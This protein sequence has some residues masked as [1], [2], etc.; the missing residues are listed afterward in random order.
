MGAAFASAALAWAAAAWPPPP[1]TPEGTA[2]VGGLWQH[3]RPLSRAAAF[4][5]PHADARRLR[6]RGRGALAASAAQAE[7]A[8]GGAEGAR[9]SVSSQ[10]GGS[11]P[12]ASLR[13]RL[14][15]APSLGELRKY[16][17]GFALS[18]AFLGCL[19]SCVM[20]AVSWPV[21]VMRTGG[22]PLLFHPALKVNPKFL[23][24]V[25]AVYFSY[26]S[27]TTPFLLA[28]S[29]GLAPAFDWLLKTL[30]QRIGCPQW[31]AMGILA[32]LYIAG[33]FGLL[34]LAVVAACAI[35]RVP[36]WA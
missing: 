2:A 16:G 36:V 1:A 5:A 35:C 27:L 20:V 22:S 18:Y 29:A 31:L 33:F 11:G 9:Q 13:R 8:A 28:G 32:L 6:G 24:Y 19:N 14:P 23:I 15:K 21:F 4:A 17:F 12:W 25:T 10:E 7:P 30:Q 3:L 34:I 26:G